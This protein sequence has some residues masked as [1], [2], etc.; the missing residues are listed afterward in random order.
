MIAGTEAA[1][2]AT[3]Q[4]NAAAPLG[5]EA[6]GAIRRL[7]CGGAERTGGA[8]IG[9][10]KSLMTPLPAGDVARTERGVRV[11]DHDATPTHE[12][13]RGV[14]RGGRLQRPAALKCARSSKRSRECVISPSWHPSSWLC[15]RGIHLRTRLRLCAHTHPQWHCV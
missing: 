5:D 4:T 11:Y 3:A 7:G 15:H 6:R 10:G 2:G 12:D 8:V 9:E 1:N 13:A 14:P